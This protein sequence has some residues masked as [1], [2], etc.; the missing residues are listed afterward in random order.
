MVDMCVQHILIWKVQSKFCQLT[1]P[2]VSVIR[3]ARVMYQV[4]LTQMHVTT[5]MLLLLMMVRVYTLTLVT[6]LVETV[7]VS[8]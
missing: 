1:T 4:V 5:I 2:A 6:S 3:V 8:V 7:L